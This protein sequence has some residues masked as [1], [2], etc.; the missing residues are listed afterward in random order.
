MDVGTDS[1]RPSWLTTGK[2]HCPWQER[3]EMFHT[4]STFHQ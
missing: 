2:L 4:E 3:I 1:K